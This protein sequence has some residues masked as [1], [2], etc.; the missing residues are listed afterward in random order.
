M[1]DTLD[2][3]EMD[4][5]RNY[6]VTLITQPDYYRYLWYFSRRMA[7]IVAACRSLQSNT[8]LL[9]EPYEIYAARPLPWCSLNE[10]CILDGRQCE[11]PRGS[12]KWHRIESDLC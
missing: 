11:T 4:D 6:Y 1:F 12:Q 5:F 2:E 8:T 9:R 7:E 3:P 10:L